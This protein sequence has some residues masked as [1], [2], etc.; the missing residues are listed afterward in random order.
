MKEKLFKKGMSPLIATILL[1][2]TAVAIGTSITS[3][4]TTF[5]EEKRLITKQELLCKY[6][7]LEVNE[8]GDRKQ[9]CYDEPSNIIDFTITNKGNIEIESFIIWVVGE[10]IYVTDLN[11]S[12][13]PGY[14]LRK[15]F[16][17]DFNTH[18]N[19]KQVHLI[20][21]I[22]KEN[23]EWQT[24]CSNKKLVLEKITPC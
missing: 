2:A 18:G 9:I 15:R 8:I 4:G 24:T 16:N 6:I 12:I 20:P 11:E 3:W 10:D 23:E 19:I 5:Y 13:K 17:Y 21:K 7:G 1:I 22:K 14:P